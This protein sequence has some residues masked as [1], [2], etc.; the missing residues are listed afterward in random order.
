MYE[1]L[2]EALAD[3]SS[4]V[5]ANRR[6]ARV[7]VDEYNAEQMAAGHA[8]WQSPSIYAWQDWLEALLSSA[9][10]QESVA[11]KISTHQSQWLWERCLRREVGGDISGMAN[12]V[13]LS[14]DTWQRLADWQITIAEV[15]RSAQSSDHRMFASAAGRYSAIL[16]REHWIDDAGLGA[17][18]LDLICDGSVTLPHT[19]TFAGFDRQRPLSVALRQALIDHGADVREPPQPEVSTAA[20][21][22]AF[23]NPDA[24]MRGAGKWARDKIDEDPD[25][26]IAIIAQSLEQ[27]A[28]RVSRLFREGETRL[29]CIQW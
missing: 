1:W 10:D 25:C 27:D 5:T 2:T 3:S 26:R 9:S 12:L 7:L 17:L 24:E 18:V 29:V 23:D 15:V 20:S 21:L 14:R 28:D 13:R 8:A 4:L 22:R 6:L 16:K 11:T 19:L